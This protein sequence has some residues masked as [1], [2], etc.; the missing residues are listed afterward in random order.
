MLASD[1]KSCAASF[2][3]GTTK[4]TSGRRIMSARLHLSLPQFENE[5]DL[6]EVRVVRGALSCLIEQTPQRRHA[7]DPAS[8]SHAI[9]QDFLDRREQ[10]AS[11]PRVE[12]MVMPV[13]RNI[14]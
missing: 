1:T 9:E 14:E 3:T 2:R 11:H 4:L 7:E 10:L 12:A 8:L 13:S 6:K 5:Q